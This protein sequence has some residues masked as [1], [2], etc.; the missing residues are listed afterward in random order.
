[1]EWVKKSTSYLRTSRPTAVNLFG[2]MDMVDELCAAAS[3][4]Q[5]LRQKVRKRKK[6]K[7]RER[8]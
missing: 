1:M 4:A 3:S 8:K 6:E 7:E 2:A 5:E